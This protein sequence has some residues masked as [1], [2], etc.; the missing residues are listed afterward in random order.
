MI[1]NT[2]VKSKLVFDPLTARALLKR[3]MKVIDC[4]PLKNDKKKTILVFEDTPE[5][6]AALAEISNSLGDACENVANVDDPR[7]ARALLKRQARL[8]DY[9]LIKDEDKSK[10]VFIFEN[11]NGLE[12]AMAEII[13]ELASKDSKELSEQ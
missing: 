5:F 12:E 13:A 8:V 2:N 3:G 1:E 10:M 9:R 11:I 4:K 6:R 7:V